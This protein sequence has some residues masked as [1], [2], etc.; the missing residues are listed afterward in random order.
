MPGSSKSEKKSTSPTSSQ[1]GT[2]TA[3]G[4]T[5]A[6]TSR[7]P[8]S[9]S[10]PAPLRLPLPSSEKPKWVPGPRYTPLPSRPTHTVTE[11]CQVEKCNLRAATTGAT[12]GFC[13]I[14][15][16]HYPGN[17]TILCISCG[18]KL[19]DHKLSDDS[20]RRSGDVVIEL[21]ENLE[22]RRNGPGGSMSW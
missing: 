18:G 4:S 15:V 14:H 3:A 19:R 21:L 11:I 10:T 9:P 22:M 17:G 12:P 2:A 7:P 20:C 5:G 8:A 13:G 16:N 6:R 1:P